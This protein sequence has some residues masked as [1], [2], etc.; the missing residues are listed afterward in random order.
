MLLLLVLLPFSLLV[1]Q[2]LLPKLLRFHHDCYCNCHCSEFS[3]FGI[4]T[5]VSIVVAITFIAILITVILI[6]VFSI[7]TT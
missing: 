6:A 5:I 3:I 4:T 7:I 2:L 1:I